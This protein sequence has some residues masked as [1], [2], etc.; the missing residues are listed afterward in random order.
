[1]PSSSRPLTG[2][3]LR[4]YGK[5]GRH[6]LPWRA[7]GRSPYELLIAEILLQRTTAAAVSG[8]YVPFVARYPTPETVVAAP[9]DE[10]EDRIAP[11]G[12]SKRAEF[13]ERCS[14]QLLARHS[15][16]IPRCRSEL[17]KL[18]GVGA[19]T[20]RSVAVHAFGENVSAVDTNVRRLISRFFGLERD[21]DAIAVL[22]DEIAP[23]DRSSDFL[24]AMLDFAADVCTPRNPECSDCPLGDDCV[25]AGLESD[26][27]SDNAD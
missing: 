1:M 4:W 5:H 8:A 20:A 15:G 6:G 2:P 11:L 7:T 25:S 22:A 16:R 9:S 23:S 12:L 10:I 27:S 21:S 17:A 24:Y 26:R 18:H 13:I 3:L 14:G 19:Y